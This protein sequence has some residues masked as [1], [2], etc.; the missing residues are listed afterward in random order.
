MTKALIFDCFGVVVTDTWVAFRDAHFG[1]NPKLLEEARDASKA[2]DLGH[3]TKDEFQHIVSRISGVPVE[4]AY[5]MLDAQSV[6]DMRVINFIRQHK[7][8]YKISMLSN[9]SP[10]RLEDFLSPDDMALFD[11]LALSYDTGFVK[12]DP[13]A[14]TNA[15]ERLGMLPEEC[16]FIDDQ[17]RNVIAAR[18]QG[19]TAVLFTTYA[20]FEQ[21]LTKLLQ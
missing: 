7:S 18:E 8:H 15:A 6:L 11:D 4:D 1:N 10:H 21:D 17:E 14:Y 19:M 3:I 5:L 13:K 16:V 20:Q 9:I 2:L 12:P